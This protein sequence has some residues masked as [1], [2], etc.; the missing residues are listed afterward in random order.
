MFLDKTG[1]KHIHNTNP[2][3]A[4]EFIK[5]ITDTKLYNP[6]INLALN[7]T[8]RSHR[9]V[10]YSVGRDRF[11][12]NCIAYWSS[13]LKYYFGIYIKKCDTGYYLHNG[14]IS[15]NIFQFPSWKSIESN[16]PIISLGHH[17]PL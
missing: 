3:P 5:S 17:E 6:A 1:F 14:M 16:I 7:K 2:I 15:N 13:A 8:R 4:D 12:R 11:V 10:L 9:R